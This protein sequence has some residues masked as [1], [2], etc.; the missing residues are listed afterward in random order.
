[1]AEGHQQTH[2]HFTHEVRLKSLRL[3]SHRAMT[4]SRGRP[5]ETPGRYS[6]TRVSEYAS[7]S[8]PTKIGE[9]ITLEK[10]KKTVK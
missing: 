2:V 4:G 8:G 10:G 7:A 5:E 6:Q 3:M 1:L 9:R